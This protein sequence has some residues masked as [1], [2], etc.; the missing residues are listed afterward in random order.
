MDPFP[1]PTSV[2]GAFPPKDGFFIGCPSLFHTLLRRPHERFLQALAAEEKLI[3]D[4]AGFTAMPFL[5]GEQWVVICGIRVRDF[6]DRKKTN[7]TIGTDFNPIMPKDSFFQ[8]VSAFRGNTPT[9]V[10][11]NPERE[12]RAQEFVSVTMHEIRKLNL[13]IKAQAEEVIYSLN[14]TLDR[15]FVEYRSENMFATSSLISTRLDAYDFHVNPEAFT[16]EPPKPIAVYKKFEKVA[17]CLNVLCRQQSVRLKLHGQSFAQVAGY[18][19]FE[20]LPFVVLENAI[21]YSPHDQE[22]GVTFSTQPKRLIVAI[23]SL[24]PMLKLGEVDRLGEHG[25]RGELAQRLKHGSG[26]GLRFAKLVCNLHNIDL[27]IT[28]ES[29]EIV[30]LDGIPFSVFR[31]QFTIPTLS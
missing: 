4:P 18:P 1:F 2:G 11:S 23:D 3:V 7:A 17:H 12:N 15:S 14:G 21:K 13:Q 5:L 26:I 16:A 27:L 20:I 31:V 29:K 9:R 19:V 24:G 6:C 10:S 30:T 28:S 25:F 22:I 8:M